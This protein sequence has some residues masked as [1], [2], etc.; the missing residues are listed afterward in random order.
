MMIAKTVTLQQYKNFQSDRSQR[1][2]YLFDLIQFS[3]CPHQQARAVKRL[4]KA[5]FIF[6]AAMLA[7][8]QT[9]SIKADGVVNSASYANPAFP[10][11][12]ITQGFV[13]IV[14]G[15]NLGPA[16]LQQ[17][18]TYPLSTT[19]G[20]NSLSVTVNGTTTKPFLLYTSAGQL[21]AVLPSSTP[22]GTGTIS[23][24]YNGQTSAPQPVTVAS[25]SFGIYSINQ[26]GTGAGIITNASYKV[27]GKSAAANPGEAY[28]IWGTG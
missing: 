22:V 11:G 13:F 1:R 14:F 10:N 26:A 2:R 8:A 28:I 9:P 6:G 21:S 25:G 27:S 16:A 12:A 18:T 20:G 3:A 24:T 19:L 17:I 5:A 7:S 4:S 23:V 15:S